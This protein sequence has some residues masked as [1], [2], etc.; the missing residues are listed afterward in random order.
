MSKLTALLE[1]TNLD[2]GNMIGRCSVYFIIDN[3]INSSIL[4]LKPDKSGDVSG[5]LSDHIINGTRN[6]RDVTILLFYST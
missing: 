2:I 4:L 6:R 3:I 5:C 1:E